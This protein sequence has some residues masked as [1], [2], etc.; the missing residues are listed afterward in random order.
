MTAC[1][2]VFEIWVTV[3]VNPGLYETDIM[4]TVP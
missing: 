2:P 4:K 1:I 3:L